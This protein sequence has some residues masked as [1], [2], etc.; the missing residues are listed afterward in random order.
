MSPQQ[1]LAAMQSMS[2]QSLERERMYALE[3]KK[4]QE[5]Q[6]EISDLIDSFISNIK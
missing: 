5:L 6:R 4:E 1:M 3:A 2:L